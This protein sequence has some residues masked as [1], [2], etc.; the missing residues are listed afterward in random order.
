VALAD[1]VVVADVAPAAVGG[2]AMT[3]RNAV[4][5]AASSG[6]NELILPDCDPL[7]DD[8]YFVGVVSSS[9]RMGLGANLGMGSSGGGVSGV[10]GSAGRALSNLT[11]SFPSLPT[12]P[13]GLSSL[14]SGI[15]SGLSTVLPGATEGEIS[16]RIST[17]TFIFK[18]WQTIYWVI[19]DRELLIY[20]NKMDYKYNPSG[21]QIK[22]RVPLVKGKIL[23]QAIKSKEYEALTGSGQLERMF[24]FMLDEEHD[25]GH[26]HLVKF[27]STHRPQVEALHKQLR[28]A[29]R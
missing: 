23:V 25:F 14:T 5:R 12:A 1:T 15:S 16:A 7:D 3:A 27:A 4:G 21:S 9:P 20:R 24:N 11:S 10:L 18:E 6:A 29:L 17:R 13:S 26:E 22:K 8:D 28:L 19:K 2:L